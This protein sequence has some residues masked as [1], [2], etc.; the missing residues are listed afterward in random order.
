[1][2]ARIAGALAAL[3]V[4][5]TG[6]ASA[7]TTT[8]DSMLASYATT[9]PPASAEV[10]AA[11]DGPALERHAFV[12]AVLARNPS[13][14]SAREAWRG[15]IARVR[16][17]G[18]F[19]D[20][21]VDLGIAPL[22]IGSSSARFGWE[23]SVSQRLPWFGKRGLEADAASAEARAAADDLEAVRRELAASAVGLYAE[24]FV[25]ARS[26]EVNATHID[27]MK[28]MQR[29]A[30]AQYETGRG[31]AQDALSAE[32]ELAHMEHDAVILASHRDVVIAQ[33]N[34]LLHRAPEAPLPPPPTELAAPADARDAKRLEEEAASRRPEIAA[35]AEHAKAEAAR[36]ERASRDAYP[37]LVVSTSYNT[38]WDMPEHRWMVGLGFNLP[39]QGTRRAG[40]ADE[41]AAARAR[42]ESEV[43]RMSDEART[44]A[45]V[46]VKH[47]EGQPASR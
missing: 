42:W 47:L 36:A 34:E 14:A 29:A 10:D 40:A 16:G 12:R 21:M 24:Y 32:A 4:A 1:M 13:I 43:A 15:A 3:A 28:A 44:Q 2:S 6:C 33:M 45:V 25:L 5:C 31:S 27:L 46:A 17:A 38:M 35:A 18:T 41:A 22:S 30:I 9:A 7:G 39:I 26:M 23:A 37:D 8:H 20:P 19:E 11:F